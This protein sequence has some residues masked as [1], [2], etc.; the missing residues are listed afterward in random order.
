MGEFPSKEHWQNC[1]GNVED[2]FL[3]IDAIIGD[4]IF[5]EFAVADHISHTVWEKGHFLGHCLR[6]NKRL[7]ASGS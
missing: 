4:I 2:G 1:Y 3:E 5:Y 6:Q 7:V